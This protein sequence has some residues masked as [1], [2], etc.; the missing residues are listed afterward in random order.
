[1]LAFRHELKPKKRF[2]IDLLDP[3]AGEA[4]GERLEFHSKRGAVDPVPCYDSSRGSFVVLWLREGSLLL[5]DETGNSTRVRVNTADFSFRHVRFVASDRG[6]LLVVTDGDSTHDT[7]A[8]FNYDAGSF[9]KL[10][11]VAT[12]ARYALSNGAVFALYD[13]H[14][15]RATSLRMCSPPRYDTFVD[16]DRCSSSVEWFNTIMTV[17]ALGRV[18]TTVVAAGSESMRLQ[19]YASSGARLRTVPLRFTTPLPMDFD[20]FVQHMSWGL[21]H[22]DK[23][24]R[25]LSMVSGG[26]DDP[27]V[28]HK[29]LVE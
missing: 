25:L 13:D 26:D 4:V 21:L 11:D 3:V 19:V 16:V 27:P 20:R 5:L 17:D 6:Q 28:I 2:V 8:L 15:G 18:F 1:M 12:A 14:A 24:N 7:L 23:Q 22:T 29:M 9:V 10:V